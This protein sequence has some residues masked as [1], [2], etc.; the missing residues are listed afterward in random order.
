MPK[1]KD[2]GWDKDG[3]PHSN[4][5]DQRNLIGSGQME[6]IIAHAISMPGPDQVCGVCKHERGTQND[7]E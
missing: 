5:G 2:Y 3:N 1:R 4:M 7:S 6:G